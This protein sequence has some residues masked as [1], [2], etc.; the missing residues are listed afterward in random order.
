VEKPCSEGL[1]VG[2]HSQATSLESGF[3]S[4]LAKNNVETQANCCFIL[5]I[6]KLFCIYGR[7]V[8]RF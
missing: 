3:S 7:Y 6:T 1:M 8:A 2:P 4:P 5:K